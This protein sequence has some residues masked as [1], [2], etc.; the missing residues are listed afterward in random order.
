VIGV[1]ERELF[2]CEDIDECSSDCL[3][4]CDHEKSVCINLM[5]SY[6]CKCKKGYYNLN[7]TL[8]DDT[9]DEELMRQNQKCIDVNECLLSEAHYHL[10][11]TNAYCLNLNGTYLCKCQSG[12]YGNGTYCEGLENLDF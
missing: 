8:G 2:Q 6:E 7:E 12:F 9:N 5:G 10:C 3:N 11:D 1:V 4:D